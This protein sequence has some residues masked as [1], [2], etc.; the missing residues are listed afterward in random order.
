MDDCPPALSDA[1]RG[2]P[3]DMLGNEGFPL[4][5][6]NA[7]FHVFSSKR[8]YFACTSYTAVE[9]KIARICDDVLHQLFR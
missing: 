4:S 3:A 8:N 7:F 2:W 5:G 9:L 6:A 1:G